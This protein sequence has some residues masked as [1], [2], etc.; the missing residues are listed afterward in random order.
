MGLAVG[1]GTAFLVT[2]G[3]RALW[4]QRRVTRCAFRGHQEARH[5]WAPEDSGGGGLRKVLLITRGLGTIPCGQRKRVELHGIPAGRLATPRALS[6]RRRAGCAIARRWASRG[7]SLW[8]EPLN[9]CRHTLQERGPARTERTGAGVPEQQ[10]DWLGR[11][12]A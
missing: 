4:I 3:G 5:R 7:Q 12:S 2:G 6:A 1:A 9:S 11:P 10:M 8:A